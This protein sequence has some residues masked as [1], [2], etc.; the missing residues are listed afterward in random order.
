MPMACSGIMCGGMGMPAGVM[1]G[2]PKNAAICGGGGAAPGAPPARWRRAAAAAAPPSRRPCPPLR[3][4]RCPRARRAR[5]RARA[6][7]SG[8]TLSEI[9]CAAAASSRLRKDWNAERD[10]ERRKP[11][12]GASSPCGFGSVSSSMVVAPVRLD[13]LHREPLDVGFLARAGARPARTA[14]RPRSGAVARLALLPLPLR[15]RRLR[16]NRLGLLRRLGLLLLLLVPGGALRLGRLR[17]GVLR[18]LRAPPPRARAAP[19][20]RRRGS[21]A[22][23]GRAPPPRAPSWA[24]PARRR[25]RPA[26]CPRR[27]SS[28]RS[29]GSG[30]SPRRARGGAAL[31]PAAEPVAAELKEACL[32]SASICCLRTGLTR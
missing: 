12:F 32:P 11:T 30:R 17:L 16:P 25:A 18:R 2:M 13:E 31:V 9:T 4:R 1:P 8:S 23:R 22:S 29:S 19:C 27:R 3:R 26:R 6:A 5:P 21:R 15:R 28:R 7:T 20:G 10:A 14:P 24:P